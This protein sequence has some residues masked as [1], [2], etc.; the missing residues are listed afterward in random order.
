MAGPVAKVQTPP[1]GSPGASSGT[2]LAP[3]PGAA[4]GA[5][6]VTDPL[7]KLIKA[8]NL[9]EFSKEAQRLA[10]LKVELNVPLAGGSYV[11]IKDR[12]D[13]TSLRCILQQG[14]DSGGLHT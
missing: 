12:L 7:L 10:K 1:K 5:S 13:W 4:Q 9:A 8:G 11:C 6:R 3:D 14:R 2:S